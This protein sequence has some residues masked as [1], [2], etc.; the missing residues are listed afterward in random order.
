MTIFMAHPARTWLLAGKMKKMTTIFFSR[1]IAFRCH[2]CCK[3]EESAF[4]NLKCNS[5]RKLYGKKF[6]NRK[7]K[8]M[9]PETSLFSKVIKNDENKK[10][11]NEQ[12][13]K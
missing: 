6:F 11:K 8:V 2:A 13:N 12:V 3:G 10:T 1:F 5:L 9:S 4:V 7:N